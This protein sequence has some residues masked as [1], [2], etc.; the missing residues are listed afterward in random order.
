MKVGDI[1]SLNIGTSEYPKII[2]LGAQCSDEEKAK[3]T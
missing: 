2:K 1:I 3:F